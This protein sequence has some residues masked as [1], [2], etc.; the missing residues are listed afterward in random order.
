VVECGRQMMTIHRQMSRWRL[1]DY[2]NAQPSDGQLVAFGTG[3]AHTILYLA[4]DFLRVLT[5]FETTVMLAT[6]LAEMNSLLNC[7]VVTVLR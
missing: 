6:P 5:I 2:S 4:D 3:M 7:V 1:G